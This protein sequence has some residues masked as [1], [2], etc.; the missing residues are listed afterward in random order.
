MTHRGAVVALAGALSI[1]TVSAAGPLAAPAAPATE[2][3]TAVS[4]PPPPPASTSAPAKTPWRERMF[5][6]GGIGLGF[7]D[8]TFVSVEPLFGVH[9]SKQIAVGAGLLY[10]WTE[11][12]RYDPNLSTTDYGGRTFAQYFPVPEFFLQAEYEYLDYEYPTSPTSTTRTSASSIFAG[13]GIYRPLGGSAGLYASAL[14]NFSYDSNDITSPY[15]SPWVIRVG[16]TAG[17]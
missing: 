10:R 5:F 12:D 6:G 2:A 4:T 3:G 11:D 14:Y 15:D 9:L 7:G 8:V 17:F 16:V 13:G 1:G